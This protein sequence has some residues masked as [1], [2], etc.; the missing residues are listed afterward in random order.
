[1]ELS[2][3]IKLDGD[4]V[5]IEANWTRAQCWD[6]MLDAP[7][8]RS[9]QSGWRRALVHNHQDG[10]TVNF[11]SDYPGGVNIEGKTNL[12]TVEAG[13]ITC[14]NIS[15]SAIKL[16]SIDVGQYRL[17]YSSIHGLVLGDDGAPGVLEIKGKG[18]QIEGRLRIFQE[19][20]FDEPIQTPDI[21]IAPKRPGGNAG[22]H[23]RYDPFKL[24]DKIADLQAQI[25]L[26]QQKVRELESRR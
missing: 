1:V 7:D 14:Q 24:S 15:C 20:R 21:T 13:E 6:L 23:P 8:R 11:A 22:D 18:L 12:E 19:A 10:L 5:T 26:L 3:D 4:W 2:S 25:E 16:G 9:S 17:A